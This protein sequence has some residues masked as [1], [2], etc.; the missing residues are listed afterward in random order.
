MNRQTLKQKMLMAHRVWSPEL[1]RSIVL[2]PWCGE[3]VT[4]AFDAHE[5]LVKRSGLN[6]KYHDLIMVP[7]NVAPVHHY[8]K[9]ETGEGH[10]KNGQ[11]REMTRRCLYYVARSLGADRIG[12]WYVSLWQD[13]GLGVKKGWLLQPHEV[14]MYQAREMFNKGYWLVND[15][16]SRWSIDGVDVRDCAFA[17]FVPAEKRKAHHKELCCARATSPRLVS[18]AR[19]GYWL[20]YLEQIIGVTR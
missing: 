4:D 3:P 18:Y 13:H 16:C 6:K 8:C 20:Q 9:E 17:Q 5:Y 12:R 15:D 14:P 1:K 10:I 11:T 19:S 7:E 2:C